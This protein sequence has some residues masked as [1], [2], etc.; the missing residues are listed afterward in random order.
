MK[1]K[2]YDRLIKK[3][4][5]INLGIMGTSIRI[6]RLLPLNQQTNYNAVLREWYGP[7]Q[8]EVVIETK[9]EIDAFK[10]SEDWKEI[11]T[12]SIHDYKCKINDNLGLVMDDITNYIVER[13]DNNK[14]YEIIFYREFIGEVHLGLRPVMGN[15]N[16]I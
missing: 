4:H 10:E 9:G 1:K 5:D 14:H 3:I 16:N 6:K 11:G 13:L 7:K 15:G 8:W 12:V 2:T